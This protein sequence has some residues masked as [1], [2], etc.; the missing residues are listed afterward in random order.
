MQNAKW[1]KLELDQ[2]WLTGLINLDTL[3]QM[4][5]GLEK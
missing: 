1:E 3:E 5:I 2:P 4:T